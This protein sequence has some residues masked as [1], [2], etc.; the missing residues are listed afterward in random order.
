MADLSAEIKE[1][2]KALNNMC[3][4]WVGL[5]IQLN[6][7]RQALLELKRLT[8]IGASH[9][10]KCGHWVARGDYT[11]ECSECGL[12]RAIRSKFCPECGAD[13]RGDENG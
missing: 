8:S 7:A 6:D 3:V 10:R 5:G 11:I 13:M 1:I 4:D 2:E 12:L 9:E